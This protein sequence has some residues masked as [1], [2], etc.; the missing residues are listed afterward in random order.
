MSPPRE[1]GRKPATTARSKSRQRKTGDRAQRTGAGLGNIPAA[2]ADIVL[3]L[4]LNGKL[5]GWSKGVE[6]VTG[7]TPHE[8]LGRPAEAFFQQDEAPVVAEKMALAFEKGCAEAE[9]HLLTKDGAPIPY[10]FTAVPLADAGGNVTG[11][12]GIGRNVSEHKAFLESLVAASPGVIYQ[13]TVSDFRITY[14]SPNVE[15]LLGFTPQEVVGAV[16]FWWGRSHPEDRERFYA[17][18]TK[19]FEEKTPVLEREFR[20]QHRDGRYLWLHSSARI[21]FDDDGNPLRVLGHVLD[22]SARKEAEDALHRAKETAEQASRSKSEFLSRM[23]HELRTPLNAILGFAQLLEMDALAPE[24]RESVQHILKGGRNLLE[25]I[26]EV[27]DVARVETGRLAFSPEPVALGAVLLESL[28][29]IAPLAAQR[30]VR[31]S[32]PDEIPTGHIMAD[33]QR[34]KQVFLNLLSNAV[35]Y[36]R[37]GGSVTLT[38]EGT[39][40]GRLRIKVHDTG[41][42]IPH[43]KLSRL[44]V[45]FD[46]LGAE[47]TGVDGTGIGLALS[48]GLVR[49]MGGEIGVDTEVHEG[50][51]FWVEFPLVEKPAGLAGPP[52]DDPQGSAPPGPGRPRTVLYIEDNLANLELIQRILAQRPEVRLIS[53]MQG[54]LGIDLARD[55]QPDLILLDL[56]LPDLTGEEIMR[57]LWEDG[58]TRQIPIAVISADATADQ[59]ERML[60]LGAR[61][62]L[63]KPLD[64]KK[65]LALMDE[66]LRDLA[67]T[68]T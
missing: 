14:V 5:T 33:R 57:G 18:L 15:R 46:R 26:N 67:S 2:V 29:L 41:V 43:D 28:E 49:L 59:V 66:T 40:E 61:T 37:R 21:E 48:R 4:D 11:F 58:R 45:P 56:Q 1:R 31:I 10:D 16:R 30:F 62:Y 17:D 50:S 53:T 52:R 64:V 34:L 51:T 32:A 63:T 9:L 44:F 8:L 23:S 38:C 47:R 13:G 60:A 55:H 25:L 3:V 42:G 7:Y 35:K 19:A 6:I 54:R 22:I 68:S 39:P 65:V 27:L 20:F 12:A 36:N 24:Q